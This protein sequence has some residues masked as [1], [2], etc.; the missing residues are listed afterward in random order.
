MGCMV[1]ATTHAPLAGAMLVYEL[2]HDE[3]IIMPVLLATVVATLACRAMHPL[4]MYTTGLAALGVRQGAMADLALL[5]RVSVGDIGHLHGTVLLDVA[6]GT[7]LVELAERDGSTDAVVL[8]AAGRYRGI[9]TP[10][11]L[12]SALLAR[13]ALDAMIV[14]DMM[15]SDLPTTTEAETLDVAFAKLSGRSADAIAVLEPRTNRYLGVL[16][17]ERLM[18]SYGQEL[19]RMG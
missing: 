2:S 18:Q 10:R 6:P 11:E 4:S 19:E 17:R 14:A 7:A 9:V 16:T 12:Q 15:R 1:A 13:D 3:T 8:D 5:R